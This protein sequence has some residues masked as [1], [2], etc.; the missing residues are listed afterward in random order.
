MRL[1]LIGATG[2]TGRQILDL[3]LDR[4]HEVT[5]FVRSPQKLQPAPRLTI[6]QGDVKDREALAA[7]VRGHDAVL[8]AIGHGP[9]DALRPSTLMADCASSTVAAMTSVGVTRLA[10]VSAAVLFPMKGIR[11]AFFRWL[12]KHH[13]RDL[14]AME[15]VVRASGLDWTIA[16]PPRLT[17][18]SDVHFRALRDGLPPGGLSMSFRAVAAFMLEAVEQRSYSHEVVGL[19][20]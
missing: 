7:A 10:I 15:R 17:K 9:P 13:A 20:R 1:F 18:S 5:T 4:G 19:C 11:F 14:G 3:A 12:L 8:S 16:R 2:K 6:V